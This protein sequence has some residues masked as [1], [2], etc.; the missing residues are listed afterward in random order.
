MGQQQTKINMIDEYL[1]KIHKLND[2]EELK[3]LHT[4]ILGSFHW[5]DEDETEL[6]QALIDYVNMKIW[7]IENNNNNIDQNI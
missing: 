2:L 3:Y 7:C 1:V 4:L 5:S 6:Y